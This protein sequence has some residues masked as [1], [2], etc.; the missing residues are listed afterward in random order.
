MP[1]NPRT[2]SSPSTAFP[3]CCPTIFTFSIRMSKALRGSGPSKQ[4]ADIEIAVWIGCRSMQDYYLARSLTSC[5]FK[6]IQAI[7]CGELVT[8]LPSEWRCPFGIFTLDS[9]LLSYLET[10][11]LSSKPL[12]FCFQDGHIPLVCILST[13]S[14]S[15]LSGLLLLSLRLCDI[16]PRFIP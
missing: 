9:L 16:S 10:F 4:V 14:L 15:C 5:R 8:F 6:Q 12:C 2:I 3:R 1:S 13:T 7:V 11:I